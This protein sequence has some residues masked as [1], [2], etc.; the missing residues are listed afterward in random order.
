MDRYPARATPPP[1][2]RREE[3]ARAWTVS[4]T[5]SA[6]IPRAV[7]EVEELL[8]ELVDELLAALAGDDPAEPVGLRVGARLVREGFI[9]PAALQATIDSLT[10]G[11]LGDLERTPDTELARRT[12]ALLGAVSAGFAD[13]LRSYTL[14][15]QEQL[16]QALFNAVVLAEQ[17]LRATENRFREVFTSSAV[18]IAITDLDGMCV[19]SNPALSQILACPPGQLAGRE[20]YDFFLPN[21]EVPV[22]GTPGDVRD[23]YRRVLEGQ[24][25]RVH[26]QRRMRT[27]NGDTVWAFLAISLVHDGAG[28]PAFFVTMVQDNSHQQLL[29]DRLTD[30]LLTDALTYLPNR[31]HFTTKLESTLGMVGPDGTV[32]LC[33]VNVDEFAA[34]N[35]GYGHE[36]G[37]EVLKVVAQRLQQAVER[38]RALVARIGPD[39]FAVLIEDRATTP[40]VDDV[41]SGIHAALAEAAYIGKRGVG[42]GASIGA[43]RHRGDEMSAADLF[44]AADTAL[45]TAKSTGRRQWAGFHP[46][47]DGPARAR[48]A[49]AAELPAAWETGQLRISYEP[50][51]RIAD[52]HAVAAHPVLVW[53]RE[54]GETL[55]HRECLALAER[56][57]M[58]VQLGPSML[59]DV[60]ARL[61]ELRVAL[62]GRA[63]ALLR[64]QLTRLQSGDGDLVRS[65]Q[66][67]LEESGARAGLLEIGLDT[68]A[69]LDDYGVARD[70]LDVL[71]AIGV[72]TG[73]CGFQGGPREL[74]LVA[75]TAVRTVMLGV[76][77]AGAA[78]RETAGAVL[79]EETERLVRAIVAGGRECAVIDVRTEA[80]ARWWAAAGVTTVQGGV[81][82]PPVAA[83]HLSALPD[84]TRPVTTG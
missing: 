36:F 37:D 34:L 60:C 27:E 42:V 68:G 50:V 67:A 77:G 71:T 29:T 41:V 70:N 25:E 72:S 59:V 44:R 26:E 18:G 83:G 21:D 61:P 38:E 78:G 3:L 62:P 9:D 10:Q 23:A 5:S 65:V 57:G 58:S 49:L 48:H 76:D 74:D 16:K 47:D 8:L 4:A 82:G 51:V 66:R 33:F 15:Q 63:G 28:D 2:F 13:G 19:E 1:E 7:V 20:L 22:R 52:E 45:R 12:V 80:E 30:Q 53:E 24:A 11:L 75:D 69:V 6:Y 81:F 56:S 40:G 43:V 39:E 14:T 35:N 31:Q 55:G 17:N 79:R 54:D 32:T 46:R 73:L 64:L 84:L